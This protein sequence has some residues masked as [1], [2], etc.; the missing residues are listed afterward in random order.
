MLNTNCPLVSRQL[1]SLLWKYFVDV[2]DS[3]GD[4]FWKR[5]IKGSG[6]VMVSV[7][8]LR[9]LT[10][11]HNCYCYK[12]NNWT[13]IEYSSR[14][15]GTKQWKNGSPGRNTNGRQNGKLICT[16]LSTGGSVCGLWWRGARADD[17]GPRWHRVDRAEEHAVHRRKCHSVHTQLHESRWLW[18][19]C[20]WC[21][22]GQSILDG[23]LNPPTVCSQGCGALDLCYPCLYH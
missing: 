18:I 3:F 15:A 1:V 23:D 6:D 2:L 20:L 22:D 7:S 16:D 12:T 17:F 11:F 19:S 10:F 9:T 4:G 8:S 21:Q 14:Q 5:K 13:K